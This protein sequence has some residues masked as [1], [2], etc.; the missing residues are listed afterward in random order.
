M[1]T[2]S[3]FGPVLVQ[4]GGQPLK[5]LRSRKALAL[6]AYVA[7]HNK[8]IAR[9]HLAELFWPD[10]SEERSH[11]NLRWV[12]NHL[13]S[14]MPE[15]LVIQRHA[16]LWG[17]SVSCDLHIFSQ[18]LQRNTSASLAAAA[19]LYRGEF[20]AGFVLDGV[21]EFELWLAGERERWLQ[22]ALQVISTLT[23]HAG[24]QGNAQMA[25]HYARRWL[26]LAPWQE[27]AHRWL[28]Y[29]LAATG[30]QS[31]AIA[32]Y[33]ICTTLLADELGVSP[34]AETV[35][36]Y[37]RI[38]EQM[39]EGKHT[40]L[41]T[42]SLPATYPIL[43]FPAHNLPRPLSPVLGRERELA[44]IAERLADSTCAWLTLLGPG[45][46]GKSCL[47]VEAAYAQ[48]MH[49]ADGVWL[50]PLVGIASVDLLPAAMAQTLAVPLQTGSDLRS[51]LLHYLS[52]KQMLL[53]LDNFEHL[54]DGV[55]LLD[56]IIAHAP[57]VKLL[58]T[59]REYLHHEAEWILDVGGLAMPPEGESEEIGTYSAVQLFVQSAHRTQATFALSAADAPYVAQICRTLEGMPLG[60]KLAAAWVRTMPCAAIAAEITHNLDFASLA[61]HGLPDRHRSLRAVL[62]SAWQ[63]L[64]DEEKRVLARLALFRRDFNGEGAQAVAGTT[65]R[66]LARLMD[67][68]LLHVDHGN[69]HNANLHNT[70]SHG[71]NH[72]NANNHSRYALHQLLA[73]FALEKLE[74]SGLMEATRKAFSGYYA[75]W[76]AQQ[77]DALTGPNPQPT[78]A[79][80]DLELD[81]IRAAWHYAVHSY[82]TAAIIA[83]TPTLSLYYDYRTLLQEALQ[84]FGDAAEILR[85]APSRV[86][87]EMALA[88][89]LGYYGLYLFRF[90]RPLEAEA[91]LQESLA[92][93]ARHN[94]PTEQAYALYVLGYNAIAAGKEAHGEEYLLSG[95]TLAET[96]GDPFL[97]VRILYA[98]GWFYASVGRPRDS[99]VALE[100]ALALAHERGDLR[101][102][103][104]TLY[105]LGRVRCEIGDYNQAKRHYE[106]SHYL[107][108]TLD[109]H[110]GIAQA[111][112]GLLQVAY[113]LGEDAEAKRLCELTIPLYEK[114]KAH[115]NTLQHI[116]AIYVRVSAAN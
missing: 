79:Q 83:A 33:K 17:K 88:K 22:Q 67:K 71:V 107:F 26:E 61:P 60:I 114:I 4:R 82:D 75:S 11:A 102:E 16:V 51:Q 27:E 94:A 34:T 64:S 98:M 1:V 3:L 53:L 81:N 84:L 77:T 68:S 108:E 2:L 32:Q 36:L 46:I 97:V 76:L 116:R 113:A 110:W 43:P 91:V 19:E 5:G 48:L 40:L 86:A 70:N 10:E 49:F 29:W 7:V 20:M 89:V 9:D 56:A 101:S 42:P 73:Q 100:R 62:D 39:V 45:G 8:P 96:L 37:Q 35:A 15:A 21:P 74:T 92:L 80:I 112:Y 50:L 103:A 104:H 25:M 66:L 52:D 28:I 41:P 95:L 23:L 30:Q 38:L 65:P 78:L 111:K 90:A 106:A 58:V 99:L 18:N 69:T 13:V 47:A 12:L 105:Y 115:A 54:L 87:N 31:A 57:R 93:A 59:S 14:V 24:T 85:G 55:E 63:R 109:V 6:L 44:Y 72:H